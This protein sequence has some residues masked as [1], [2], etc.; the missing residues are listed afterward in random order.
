[1]TTREILIA[2]REKIAD[3]AHWT[4]EC[5]ARDEKGESVNYDAQ[6]ACR[7]CAKGAYYLTS[8]DKRR[9]DAWKLLLRS[10]YEI[11]ASHPP[12]RDGCPIAYVNDTLGHG[13]VMRMFSKAVELAGVEIGG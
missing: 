9:D 6:E 1:M 2:I 10:A 8:T 4:Q 5:Y 13:A 3:P 12:T 11:Q 7:W